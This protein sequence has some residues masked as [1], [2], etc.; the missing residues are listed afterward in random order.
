MVERKAIPA[1]LRFKVLKR[2]GFSCVYCGAHGRAVELHVDHVKPVALGGTNAITNLATSCAPCNL[3]KRHHPLNDNEGETDSQRIERQGSERR[4]AWL[5]ALYI[6][7]SV[8]DFMREIFPWCDCMD[9]AYGIG[10]PNWPHAL[11]L[12][13]GLQATGFIEPDPTQG[14][15]SVTEINADGDLMAS[16][17]FRSRWPQE[18]QTDGRAGEL[19]SFCFPENF[20]TVEGIYG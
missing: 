20:S 16:F 8:K 15:S 19:S 2:D 17:M 14:C 10:H 9:S 5:A 4:H 12:L 3:G 7:E 11:P 18:G 1:G 13:H 6:D